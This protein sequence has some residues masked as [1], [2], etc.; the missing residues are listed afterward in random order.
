M[1]KRK[2]YKLDK[3][4]KVNVPIIISEDI[5]KLIRLIDEVKEPNQLLHQFILMTEDIIKRG[6][7]DLKNNDKNKR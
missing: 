7:E 2:H 3:T 1:G 4:F 5:K 6:E